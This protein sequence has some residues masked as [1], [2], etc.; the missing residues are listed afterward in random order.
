MTPRS[1]LRIVENGNL[2][3]AQKI[4]AKENFDAIPV[5]ERGAI[6]AFGAARS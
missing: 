5:V 2:Q 1:V 6:R 3:S 4:A